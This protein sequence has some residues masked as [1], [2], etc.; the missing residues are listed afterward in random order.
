MELRVTIEIEATT[1]DGFDDVK[2]CTVSENANT[3]RFE[4]AVFDED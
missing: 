3:L 4:A 2:I 1:P